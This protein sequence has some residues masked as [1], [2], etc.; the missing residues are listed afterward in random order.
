MLRV[1][2]PTATL[3]I[4]KKGEPKKVLVFE[5]NG[6]F[7]NKLL[8]PGGKVKVGEQSFLDTAITEAGE[9]VGITD[10][11]KIK[12]FTLSSRPRRDV[13]HVSLETFLDGKPVP[14]GLENS[15]L[16][17]EAHHCFD[18]VYVAETGMEP[19]P[20]NEETKKVF[21]IDAFGVDPDEFALDHGRLITAYASFLMTGQLPELDEF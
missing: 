14:L 13:R 6:K 19:T 9:E 20:D 17:I 11:S 2:V 16:V 8:L 18:A 15:D 12:L 10:L 5:S 4:I 1:A 3:L 7:G 21:F